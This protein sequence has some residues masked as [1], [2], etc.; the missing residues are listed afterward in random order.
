MFNEN[1]Q[2]RPSYLHYYSQVL[3]IHPNKRKGILR[4]VSPQTRFQYF[5]AQKTPPQRVWRE[6]GAPERTRTSDPRI[7]NPVLCPAELPGLFNFFPL[8]IGVLSYYG[9]P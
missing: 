9:R 7:R 6:N 2:V 8:F 1:S 5:Q 4:L 3:S